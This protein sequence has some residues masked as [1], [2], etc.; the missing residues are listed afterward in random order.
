M[1]FHET[2]SKACWKS[3]DTNNPGIFCCF[4]SKRI[5]YTVR[6][7]SPIYLPEIKPFWSL[8]IS[9]F[10][11]DFSLLAITEDISLYLT[12]KSEIGLQ[13]FRN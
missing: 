13:F 5:S 3:T 2:V 12:F 4:V 8:L 6:I 9:L 1:N 11:T 7:F 10:K